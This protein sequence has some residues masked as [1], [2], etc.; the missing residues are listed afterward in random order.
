MCQSF[1][2]CDSI[3]K[4]IYLIASFFQAGNSDISAERTTKF[5]SFLRII[6]VILAFCAFVFGLFLLLF[7]CLTSLQLIANNSH[8]PTR[9]NLIV[10][11]TKFYC[12]KLPNTV[13]RC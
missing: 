12:V 4:M 5:V 6:N 11:L 8:R 2:F 1:C 10:S 7:S 3:R 9:V 13:K